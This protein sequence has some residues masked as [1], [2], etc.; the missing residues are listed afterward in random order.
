MINLSEEGV[1]TKTDREM[2]GVCVAHLDVVA[3]SRVRNPAALVAVAAAEA[4]AAKN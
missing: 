3:E 2:E 1:G 4:D